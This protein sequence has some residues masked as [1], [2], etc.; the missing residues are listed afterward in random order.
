VAYPEPIPGLVICYSYLWRREHLAG[1]EEGQK[2]RPCAIVAAIRTD[3]GETRVL[4]LPVTHTQ[5]GAGV[6]AIEIPQVIG[7]RLGLDA[8]RSWIVVSEYNE[9]VWPGPD[10]R[11]V[12]GAND[13]SVAYGFLPPR[14]FEA[15]R[16]ALLSQVAR[17]RGP[18]VRRSE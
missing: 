12:P 8:L 13:G 9:F 2:N 16:S 11:P 15:V 14:F 18:A 17:R 5:P 7:R 6:E 10:L 3:A 4:V 1:L